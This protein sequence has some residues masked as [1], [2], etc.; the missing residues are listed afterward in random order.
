MLILIRMLIL[1]LE[2]NGLLRHGAQ[3]EAAGELERGERVRRGARDPEREH[4]PLATRVLCVGVKT[5]RFVEA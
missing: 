4:E 3:P 5:R 1:T 2:L